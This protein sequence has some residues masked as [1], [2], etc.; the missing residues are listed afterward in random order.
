MGEGDGA[1]LSGLIFL[2]RTA[3]PPLLPPGDGAAR[4]EPAETGEGVAQ[5]WGGHDRARPWGLLRYGPFSGT[6]PA[7]LIPAIA[8]GPVAAGGLERKP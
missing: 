4:G 1:G 6:G 8:H 7:G 2:L 5:V 3:R